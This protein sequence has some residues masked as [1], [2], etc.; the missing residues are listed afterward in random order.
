MNQNQKNPYA[1]FSISERAQ[2]FV[3]AAEEDLIPVFA[4]IEA[5]EYSNQAKVLHAL[6]REKIALHHFTPT[7]RV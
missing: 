1:E 7:T 2:A 6:Q 5:T 4:R 3:K